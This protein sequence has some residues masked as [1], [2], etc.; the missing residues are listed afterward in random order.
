MKDMVQT[1][2]LCVARTPPNYCSLTLCLR[3]LSPIDGTADVLLLFTRLIVLVFF[4]L[5]PL[6]RGRADDYPPTALRTVRHAC[7][8]PAAFVSFRCSLERSKQNN[9]NTPLYGNAM[10]GSCSHLAFKRT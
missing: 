4:P 10:L 6:R 1:I 2:G 8:R 3:A 9:Q 7:P 5:F